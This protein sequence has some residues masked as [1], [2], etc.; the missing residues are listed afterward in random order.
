MLK[1]IFQK[2]Q[3]KQGCVV[4]AGHD[5]ELPDQSFVIFDKHSQSITCLSSR[6]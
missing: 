1:T 5:L 6:T 4:V 2:F 3:K